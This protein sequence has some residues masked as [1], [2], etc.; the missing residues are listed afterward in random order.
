VHQLFGFA[1]RHDRVRMLVYYQGF[2]ASD[3]HRIWHYPRARTALRRE[4]NHNRIKQ[5]AHGSRRPKPTEP[6]DEPGTPPPDGGAVS[7]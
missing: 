6:S 3:P 4:L 1:K 5:Y 2:D 7:P